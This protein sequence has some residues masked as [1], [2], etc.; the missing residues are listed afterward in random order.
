[1]NPYETQEVETTD[2][3]ANASKI[4]LEIKAKLELIELTAEVQCMANRTAQHQAGM[5]AEPVA[6]LEEFGNW[7][8]FDAGI[9]LCSPADAVSGLPQMEHD[10]NANG[11]DGKGID[12]GEAMKLGEPHDSLFIAAV[13]RALGI[14]LTPRDL[15]S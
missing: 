4:C 11:R 1:M 2:A 13:N 6:Y 5:D 3:E 8:L 14:E 9:L 15:C 10:T 7:V 12:W